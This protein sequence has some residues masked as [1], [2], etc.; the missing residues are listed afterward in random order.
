MTLLAYTLAFALIGLFAGLIAR[1]YMPG[2][3]AAD[4]RAHGLL[5]VAGSVSG[6]LSWL[7]LRWWSWTET[8]A[9]AGRGPEGSAYSGADS[10]QTQM[11]GYWIGLLAAPISALLVLAVY[12]LLKG[13]RETA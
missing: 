12:K 6:G 10:A 9:A 13:T 1:R 11:P 5:G 4:Y 3:D 2:G 8:V 7:W